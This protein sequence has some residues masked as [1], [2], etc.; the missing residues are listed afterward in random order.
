MAI[1]RAVHVSCDGWLLAAPC[2][3][4][5]DC[6]DSWGDEFDGM[7]EARRTVQGNGWR[8]ARVGLTEVVLCPACAARNPGR[9]KLQDDPGVLAYAPKIGR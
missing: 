5:D 2:V 8:I 3:R 4:A 7:T 6:E 1:V 9:L